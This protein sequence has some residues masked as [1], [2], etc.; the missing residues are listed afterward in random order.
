M[1]RATLSPMRILVVEDDKKIASFVVNGLKQSGYAVDH[2]SDGEDGLF[3]AQTIAY[4]ATVVDLMLPKLDGLGLIQQARAHG[5]RTPVRILS[6]KASVD[7]RVKGLQAG[8]DDYP[9]KPF[10]ISELLARIQALIRRA[11]KTPEPTRL[12]VGDL[13]LDLLTREVKRGADKIELQPREFAL[14]EYMMRHANR[15]VTKTMILEHIF[16]YSFDTQTHVVDVLVHRLRSKVD[17]DKAMIHTLR[18]VGYVLRPA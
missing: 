5:V 10:P 4:D 11:T 12:V 14:L 3:R 6:A 7:D 9:T 18:G 15:P 2:S 8:S 1:L 16:D 13:T 17:K